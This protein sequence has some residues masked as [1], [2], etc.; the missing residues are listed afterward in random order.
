MQAVVLAAGM[1]TRLRP[2]TGDRSKAMVPVLGRPLVEWAILPLTKNAIRDFVFVISPDDTEITRYFTERTSLEITARFVVQE[3]RLGMA[4]ALDLAAPLIDGRFV[5]SACDS[6]VDPW[7]VRDLFSVG[8]G[9][10]AVLSLLDVEPE[11]LCRS[12]VVE[13][14]GA[15]I[16]RIVEKPAPGEAPSNTVSLPHYV[17]SPKLLELLPSVE[18]SPRGE[19]EIQDAIQGLIDDDRTVIG[20]RARKRFQVSSPD[21]LLQL[22]RQLLSDGSEPF[23]IGP[24]NV[25]PGLTL[26][27]PYRIEPGVVL[28][29]SC[30]IGPEVFLES[31][32]HIGRG[33]VVRRSI[34]LRKGVVE[35]G[36]VVESRVVT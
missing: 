11:M 33:A 25:S 27:E 24:T 4:H 32:C 18:R 22:T 2:V 21:D 36:E 10:D 13:L 35:D 7:H 12:G 29:D 20:V 15:R 3:E 6:L 28:G 34:V 5:V 23:R 14:E 17:F 16:R 19:H 26:I 8:E 30:E 9:A 1:G 31:G